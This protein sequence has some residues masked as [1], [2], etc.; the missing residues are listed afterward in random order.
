MSRGLPDASVSS[1]TGW[2]GWCTFSCPLYKVSSVPPPL[3]AGDWSEFVA[4]TGSHSA[5][6]KA[7]SQP[8]VA[9]GK[10]FQ[11]SNRKWPCILR[12]GSSQSSWEPRVVK[13]LCTDFHFFPHQNKPT[14]NSVSPWDISGTSR[15]ILLMDV[16]LGPALF[17]DILPCLWA[18]VRREPGGRCALWALQEVISWLEDCGVYLEP[19]SQLEADSAGTV[20]SRQGV[21]EVF[22]LFSSL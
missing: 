4:D 18:V 11:V 7:L 14:L 12:T 20:Q 17:G 5:N 9:A 13:K 19:G 8:A 16:R 3:F 2:T 10:D 21:V 22:C 15:C 6:G 1:V